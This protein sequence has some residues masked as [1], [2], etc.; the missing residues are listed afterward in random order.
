M[1]GSIGGFCDKPPACTAPAECAWNYSYTLNVSYSG[2]WWSGF[3]LGATGPNGPVASPVGSSTI[4]TP[5]GRAEANCTKEANPEYDI[6]VRTETVDENG[7][8]VYTAWQ[9]I[10]TVSAKFS[11]G[12]CNVVIEPPDSDQ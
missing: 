8:T 3:Q 5:A 2:G 4:T 11:C 12:N 7:N 9:H 10:G 6:F 1:S